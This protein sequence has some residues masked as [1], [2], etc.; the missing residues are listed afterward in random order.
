MSDFSDYMS[1]IDAQASLPEELADELVA[2][3]A[4]DSAALALGHRVD[5]QVLQEMLPAVNTL[6]DAEW[7]VPDATPASLDPDDQDDDDA[8]PHRRL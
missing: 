7:V 8:Q 1:R 6:P 5:M 4:K 2:G 3:V